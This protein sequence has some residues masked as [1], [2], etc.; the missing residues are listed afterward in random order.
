MVPFLTVSP[1]LTMGSV[2][3]EH[4][5]R[6]LLAFPSKE[7]AHSRGICS[8]ASHALPPTA[9]VDVDS[10]AG[11]FSTIRIKVLPVCAL[12]CRLQLLWERDHP[13]LGREGNTQHKGVP[14]HPRP[15]EGTVRQTENN[16]ALPRIKARQRPGHCSGLCSHLWWSRGAN[17][18]G[19]HNQDFSH[20]KLP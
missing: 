16:P 20:L 12:A 5:R 18:L 8:E 15:L 1:F 3:T 19:T 17:R 14:F 7:P 10:T 11:P 2:S 9:D 4:F 6:G 13:S